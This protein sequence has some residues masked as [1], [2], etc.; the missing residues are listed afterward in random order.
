ML[1]SVTTARNG[2]TLLDPRV[3]T[4]GLNHAGLSTSKNQKPLAPS[5]RSHLS[6]ASSSSIGHTWSVMLDSI[7]GVTRSVL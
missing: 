6:Y 1:I 7:A 3:S 5:L 2:V 4:S